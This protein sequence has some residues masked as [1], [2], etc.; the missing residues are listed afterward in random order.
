MTSQ[1]LEQK[2][3]KID[4]KEWLPI[5]GIYQSI[6]DFGEGKPSVLDDVDSVKFFGNAF[7]QVVSIST[8]TIVLYKLAERLF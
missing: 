3:K 7:Y 5:Y 4:K 2:T 1:T 8:A 6:K